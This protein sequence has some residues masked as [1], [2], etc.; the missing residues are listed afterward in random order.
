VSRDTEDAPEAR[1]AAVRRLG[2]PTR[3]NAVVERLGTSV[4]VSGE[5]A[6]P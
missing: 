3:T 4:T 6:F 5:V 1:V 2:A